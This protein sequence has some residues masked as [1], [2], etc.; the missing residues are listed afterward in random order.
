M[1]EIEGRVIL[2]VYKPLVFSL[3]A[4]AATEKSFEICEGCE[5]E[6][7]RFRNGCSIAESYRKEP[8]KV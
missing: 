8:R 1:K 5:F 3:A 7:G 2:V 4:Q 6:L